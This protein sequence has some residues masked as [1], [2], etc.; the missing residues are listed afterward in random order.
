LV[1]M[2]LMVLHIKLLQLFLY[3]ANQHLVKSLKRSPS[4]DNYSSNQITAYSMWKKKITDL[5]TQ[6]IMIY[7]PLRNK[8][9]SPYEMHNVEMN[10]GFDTITDYWAGELTTGPD[11]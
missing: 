7:F 4:S 11:N 10:I 3:V 6:F 2:L 1:L 5:V 8:R 9:S